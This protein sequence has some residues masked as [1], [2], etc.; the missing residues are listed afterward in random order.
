M[1]EGYSKIRNEALAYA[2]SYMN[3]IE[4]WGSGIP[5]IIG[6]VKAAELQE[7]EFIGGDVDLRIN[8][9]RNRNK[10]NSGMNDSAGVVNAAGLPDSADK[11]PINCRQTADKLPT[12]EQ[13]HL[14]YKYVLE[15]NGIT[16]AKAMKLLDL[17]E[18]RSRDLLVKMVKNGW[19]RKEGASRSTIY[20]QNAEKGNK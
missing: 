9:Y 6:K 15:N 16:T 20:V 12:N 11:P 7:P 17:K 5:R 4:Q 14:V 8:I 19:L 10:A 2:F 18:R 13:E 1:K 3:L